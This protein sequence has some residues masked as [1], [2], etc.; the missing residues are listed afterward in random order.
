M[1]RGTGV[2]AASASSIEITFEYRGQ[3]CREKLKLPPNP[4]NFKYAAGLKATV[5]HE[6]AVGSFDYARHFPKSR[7]VRKF[8]NNPART[9]T[10]GE[11]LTDWLRDTRASLEP[12]TYADYSE[13]VENTWRP[14]L[15]KRWLSDLTAAWVY[16]WIG[17]QTVSKKRILNL[18]TP[19][20]QAVRYAVKPR[21]LLT[22]DPIGKLTVKRPAGIGESDV[23]I[24]PFTAEEIE[25]ILPHL[26]PELAAMCQFWVWTGLRVG[27]LIALKWSDIDFERGIARITKAARG[28]RRKA[29]K[30]KAGVREVKL[31]PPALEAL[32]RAKPFTRLLHA[33]IF[34]DPGTRPM[35]NNHAPNRAIAPWANDKQIRVRWAAALKAAGVRYRFPRQLRHTYASWMLKFREDPAWI[36][37]QMGHRNVGVTLETYAK[38]IPAMNPNAGM[39][40]YAAIM[41]SK[42]GHD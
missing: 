40:A 36:A 28:N 39:G 3:R 30:T 2:R 9:I 18:L 27:E 25:A 11:L 23:L 8:A 41:A 1:G 14:L 26:E 15:G 20:R 4:A 37:E 5:E 22:E 13:Y 10:V 7:K 34:Q 16:Q 6:I 42:K 29:P 31:L 12:E 32:Q 38:Y 19:L 35:G 24:D 21:K 17:E 33:E